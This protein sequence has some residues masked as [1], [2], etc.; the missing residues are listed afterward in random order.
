MTPVRKIAV[1][2]RSHMVALKNA[3]D[4]GKFDPGGPGG[5]EL[6]FFGAPNDSFRSGLRT[7]NGV[8]RGDARA[9][10]MFLTTSGGQADHLDPRDY[11]AVVVYGSYFT[12]Q[13]FFSTLIRNAPGPGPLGLSQA[14]LRAAA[15]DWLTAMPTLDIIRAFRDRAPDTPVV[16]AFEPFYSQRYQSKLRKGV[17]ISADQ[18]EIVFDALAEAVRAAGAVPFFQPR[19][20][21]ADTIY[22]QDALSHGSRKLVDGSEHDPDDM[23]HLNS[24]YGAMAL[25][26]IMDLL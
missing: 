17:T 11:D 16:L 12:I 14:F 18:R 26:G 24:T 23:T 6:V 5:N 2:G 10:K 9:G 13:T 22:S 21:M 4:E 25:S 3:V 15:A 1:L 19:S 8:L 7:E 20:T